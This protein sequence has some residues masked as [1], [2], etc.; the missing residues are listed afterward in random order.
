MAG[1]EIEVSADKLQ[2]SPIETIDG[3]NNVTTVVNRVNAPTTTSE[4]E[5]SSTSGGWSA[6]QSLA[7]G[8][9][10]GT[11]VSTGQWIFSAGS[12]IGTIG[13]WSVGINS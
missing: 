4:D 11:A 7:S 9:K 8:A 2:G 13:G 1:H 3:L 12:W 5:S 10:N 6:I